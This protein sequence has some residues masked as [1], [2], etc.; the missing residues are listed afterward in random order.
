MH[1][2]LPTD[3]S[4]LDIAPQFA[5]FIHQTEQ[6]WLFTGAL[7]D[8]HGCF[9]IRTHQ[10]RA[11][12][13]AWWLA[14]GED[15]GPLL[16]CHTC[17]VRNCQRTDDEGTYLVAGVAY[18]RVGHLF[19]APQAANMA[20][21][22][23]KGRSLAGDRNPSRLYPERLAR[24][25]RHPRHLDPIG[26]GNGRRRVSDADADAIQTA[27]GNGARVVELTEQ[28]GYSVSTIARIRRGTQWRQP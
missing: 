9:C 15:P 10:Y 21:M 16:V 26:W 28:Y 27:L 5:R 19:L 17:D 2:P 4:P 1:R 12:R 8:G 11:S 24:G 7:C 22:V 14:T 20:D 3:V 6:H 18:R 23:A 25:D 13:V